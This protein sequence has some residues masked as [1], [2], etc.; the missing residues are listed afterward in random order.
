[1]GQFKD[2]I[3]KQFPP[4]TD[5]ERAE[6]YARRAAFLATPEPLSHVLLRACAI[7]LAFIAIPVVFRLMSA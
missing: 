2:A 4:K 7:G 1:M 6:Y 3:D 5:Q